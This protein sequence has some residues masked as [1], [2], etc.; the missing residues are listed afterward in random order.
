MTCT[1]TIANHCVSL[2]VWIH[3]EIYYLR[4]NLT[5]RVESHFISNPRIKRELSRP[6]S[7]QS[8]TRAAK[9]RA[10]AAEAVRDLGNAKRVPKSAP[11]VWRQH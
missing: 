2:C 7:R 3:V 9:V 1:F 10:D 6:L 4:T 11:D 5:Y 8:I